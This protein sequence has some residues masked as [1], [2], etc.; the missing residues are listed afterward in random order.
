MKKIL[1]LSD[2]H[3]KNDIMEKVIKKESP[4]III[5]CGDHCMNDQN[6]LDNTFDYYVKGNNDCIGNNQVITKIN[7]TSFLIVHGDEYNVYSNDL[8]NMVKYATD[9]GV[10]VVLYGHSHIEDYNKINDIILINPGSITYPRNQNGKKSYAIIH[11]DDKGV[12][13]KT[14]EEMVRYI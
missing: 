11:V 8:T 12:I 7:N 10:N 3:G 4:D 2:S 13:E 9:L 14:F 6:Y 5:H 1:I